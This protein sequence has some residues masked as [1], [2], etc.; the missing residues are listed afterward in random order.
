VI[1]AYNADLGLRMGE[2]LGRPEIVAA[3]KTILEAEQFVLRAP[4]GKVRASLAL[5]GDE[6]MGLDLFD[7]DDKLVFQAPVY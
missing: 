1:A 2:A 3:K 4:D 5:C 7:R 6:A